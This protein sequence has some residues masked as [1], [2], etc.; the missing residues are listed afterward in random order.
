MNKK[1]NIE[2][3]IPCDEYSADEASDDSFAKIDIKKANPIKS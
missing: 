1:L 3:A 2:S